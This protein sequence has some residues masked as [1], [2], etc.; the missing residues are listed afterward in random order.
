VS[1]RRVRSRPVTGQSYPANDGGGLGLLRRCISLIYAGQKPHCACPSG[2][3]LIYTLRS[4]PGEGACQKGR[5]RILLPCPE[6]ATPVKDMIQSVGDIKIKTPLGKALN[7][8]PRNSSLT[9]T[10]SCPQLAAGNITT[11]QGPDKAHQLAC[12]SYHRRAFVFS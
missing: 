11:H 1:T 10:L 2:A 3:T 6:F 7:I 8:H 5:T 12:N 4:G 9:A